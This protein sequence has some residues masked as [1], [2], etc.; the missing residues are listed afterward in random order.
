VGSTSEELRGDDH[1]RMWRSGAGGCNRYN[2]NLHQV[3]HGRRRDPQN[4]RRLV[5]CQMHV[6]EETCP[7]HWYGLKDMN[8]GFFQQAVVGDR[9]EP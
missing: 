9:A 8:K 6:T 2:L 4:G 5:E 1:P 3:F 7:Q